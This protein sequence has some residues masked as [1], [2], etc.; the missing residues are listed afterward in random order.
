MLLMTSGAAKALA[1]S[2]SVRIVSSPLRA[3]ADRWLAST[4]PCVGACTTRRS[5]ATS[6]CCGRWP[7]PRCRSAAVRRSQTGPRGPVSWPPS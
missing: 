7:A 4:P 2:R 3:A 1:S 5:G 6:T